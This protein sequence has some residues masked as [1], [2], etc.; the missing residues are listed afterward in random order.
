MQ[1]STLRALRYFGAF[2]GDQIRPWL[3]QIV[4][5]T[6]YAWLAK[7][8]PTE[9][10]ALQAQIEVLRWLRDDVRKHAGYHAAPVALRAA[11]ADASAGAPPERIGAGAGGGVRAA[12][13][14]WFAW[15]PLAVALAVALFAAIGVDVVMSERWHDERLRDQVIASHAPAT[16]SERLVDVASSDHHVVKPFLS[17]RL[18][19]SP[20]VRALTIPGSVFLG[21]RVDYLE[22]RPVA[23][24]VYR[25][26][27]HIVEDCVWP[28]KD[29]DST[30]A[31]TAARGFRLARWSREGL[32]HCLISDVSPDV[33]AAITT[34]LERAPGS[35]GSD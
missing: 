24:L 16:M 6:C 28:T 21:G 30:V 31:V 15:R 4:R 32:A 1:E 17:S 18:D 2:R 29:G 35:A 34:E 22:G 26:G 33:F 19:F 20:P 25:Q 7:D 14:R 27:R 23:A 8:R 5:H 9:V 13:S 3:L 11:F 12:L 10:M